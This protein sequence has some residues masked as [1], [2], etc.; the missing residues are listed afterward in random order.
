MRCT[1][2]RRRNKGKHATNGQRVA[3]QRNIRSALDWLAVSGLD[4]TSATQGDLEQWQASTHA[5]AR[6]DAGHFV[7]WARRNKLTSL[8]FAAIKWDGPRRTIDLS[9]IHI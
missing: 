1:G 8:D 4:L 3:V 6:V 5:T 9:L 2:L 7:R